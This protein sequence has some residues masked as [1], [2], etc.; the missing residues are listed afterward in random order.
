MPPMAV[1]REDERAGAIEHFEDGAL[2]D[3]DYRRRRD[4]VRFYRT[5]AIEQGGP[6]LTWPAAP[7]ASWCPCCATA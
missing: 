4:D 1:T 6:V 3:F 5:L 7:G 2:Y